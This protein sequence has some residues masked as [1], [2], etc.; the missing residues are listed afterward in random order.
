MWVLEVMLCRAVYFVMT[1]HAIRA[2]ALPA[3]S[4]FMSSGPA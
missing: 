1:P 4:V 3:E 2:P